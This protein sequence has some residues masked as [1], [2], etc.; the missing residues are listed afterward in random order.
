VRPE[1]GAPAA[2]T[3]VAEDLATEAAGF[4]EGTAR[5][6]GLSDLAT[7]PP[8]LPAGAA[9]CF[10]PVVFAAVVLVVAALA[11]FTAG[12][13]TGLLAAVLLEVEALAPGFFAVGLLA[14]FEL[15]AAVFDAAGFVAAL[16][17]TAV[18]LAGTG[19][20]FAAVPV[21]LAALVDLPAAVVVLVAALVVGFAA[22]LL[23]EL[24]A[25]LAP[26]V[27]AAGF[28]AVCAPAVGVQKLHHTAAA[29]SV[30]GPVKMEFLRTAHYYQRYL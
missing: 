8:D 26:A 25:F 16:D 21:L 11:D 20:R 27:A 13:A 19:E 5:A 30:S 7:D 1:R 10:F 2:F 12:F 4:F 14:V 9:G 29:K 17:F 24:P 6:A 23:V 15:F 28:L 18:G 22:G 3:G